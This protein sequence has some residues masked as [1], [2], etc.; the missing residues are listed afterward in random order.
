MKRLQDKVAVVT[1]GGT[2]IGRAIALK[3][4]REGANLVVATNVKAEVESVAKEIRDLGRE[5]IAFVIDVTDHVK[6][7]QMA[8]E[9]IKRFGKVDIIV[10]AAGVEGARDFIVNTSPEAWRKTIEI[11]LNAGFY[12]LKAFLPKMMEQKS[13]RVIMLS[14]ASGKLPAAMNADYSASKHG[15]IGLT[16][17]LALE[18][19]VLGLGMITSN[20]IC[21]GPIATP[22]MDRIID[23]RLK[24]LF[25]NET[26]EQILARVTSRTI[27][28]RMLDPEEVANMAAYLASDD[29]KGVTGQAMNIDGGLVLW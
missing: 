23:Q 28:A 7:K 17:A 21:P 3:F 11:N 13:G 12:T 8:D 24:P 22:M 5:G 9:V 16:K 18:L 6:V 4:A 26:E 20:A 2:G 14:S 19:G 25:A 10:T 15:V 27:Q 1:G 29:A